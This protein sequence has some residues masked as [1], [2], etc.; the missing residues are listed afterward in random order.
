MAR[1]DR[2]ERMDRRREE[3]EGEYREALIAAL[4]V[5]AAGQWGL[6]G[7]TRDKTHLARAKPL[8]AGL[9][10]LAEEID[11][12]RDKLD[13]TPFELHAEFLAA[14]GPTHSHAVGEPKQ[15]QAWLDRLAG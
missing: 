7:H 9:D 2:L 14:R 3:A 6:F 5:T 13:L 11:D 12:L 15:A 1:A 4:K 10:E 8:L